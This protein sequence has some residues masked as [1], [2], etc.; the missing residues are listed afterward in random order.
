MGLMMLWM[1][2]LD[3][4]LGSEGAAFVV[5]VLLDFLVHMV[6]VCYLENFC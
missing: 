4:W 5:G 1:M 2:I 3:E 6:F